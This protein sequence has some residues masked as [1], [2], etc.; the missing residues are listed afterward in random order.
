MR[1]YLYQVVRLDDDGTEHE[2]D[3]FVISEH[4]DLPDR[5]DH[6]DNPR[7]MKPGEHLCPVTE[8]DAIIHGV[9]WCRR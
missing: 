6:D 3:D 1:A 7:V 8:N 5:P 9:V 4:D 2:L